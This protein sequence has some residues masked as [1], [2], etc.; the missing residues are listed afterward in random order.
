MTR[1]FVLIIE[2]DP[3]LGTIFNRAL[4]SIGFETALDADGNRYKTIL[5]MRLP[6]LIVLDLHLPYASGHEVLSELRKR[7]PAAHLP[8]IVVTAD[9]FGARELQASGETV[10]L[11]PVSPKRLNETALQSI[12]SLKGDL[13]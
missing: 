4:E 5:L 13:Q 1:P 9:I 7:Y 10:L 8:V 6:D 3:M 12:K 11:K 2:D